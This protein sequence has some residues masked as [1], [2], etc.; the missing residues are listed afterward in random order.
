M[1]EKTIINFNPIFSKDGIEKRIRVNHFFT[2]IFFLFELIIIV[3]F[4]YYFFKFEIIFIYNSIISKQK[5]TITDKNVY[6]NYM[7]Q[8]KNIIEMPKY[9]FNTGLHWVPRF[10]SDKN[11]LALDGNIIIFDNEKDCK[12]FIGN[13]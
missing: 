6:N 9:C 2:Y 3:F 11:M 12:L 1:E 13:V 5:F 4:F 10:S 7:T 8:I